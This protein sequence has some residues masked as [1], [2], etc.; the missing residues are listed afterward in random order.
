MNC[1]DRVRA[2]FQFEETDIVPY[3]LPVEEPIA[4]HLDSHYGSAAWRGRL[5]QHIGFVGPASLGLPGTG[6]PTNTDPF[7]S[8]W[9]SYMRPA[10]L[11][12]PALAEPGLTGYVWPTVESVWDEVLIQQ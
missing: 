11:A 9:H 4:A 5:Q 8:V 3:Q 12:A 10:H 7:G 2:A 6:G 1:R